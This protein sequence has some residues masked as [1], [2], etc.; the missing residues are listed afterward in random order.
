MAQKLNKREKQ[1]LEQIEDDP[2]N[3]PVIARRI[4]RLER[5]L[6]KCQSLIQEG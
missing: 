4:Y 6:K 3:I 5:R 2:I 1:I